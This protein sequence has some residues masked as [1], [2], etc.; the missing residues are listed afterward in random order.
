MSTESKTH[1]TARSQP[2]RPQ[3]SIHRLL[4]ILATIT[5]VAL[6]FY[7]ATELRRRGRQAT[8][9]EFQVRWAMLGAATNPGASCDEEVTKL[10]LIDSQLHL[11]PPE[12]GNLTNLTR[13]NLA[14]NQFAT[15]PHEIDQLANLTYMVL[16]D[17]QFTTLPPEICDLTS[18]TYLVLSDNQLTTLPPEIGNLTNLEE[19]HLDG[20]QLSVLP[21]EI[22]QIKNLKLLNVRGNKISP[23][24]IEGL[25]ATLPQCEIWHD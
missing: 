8:V 1:S 11:L 12:I 25:K 23:S 19:L 6:A 20:N 5:C 3:F 15:L 22:G 2:R 21:P 7:I 4:P 18:L 14:H 10:L 16:S 17:N 13:L 24:D 9:E